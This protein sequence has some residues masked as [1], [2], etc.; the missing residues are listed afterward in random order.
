MGDDHRVTYSRVVSPAMSQLR[1]AL[2]DIC[3]H[4]DVVLVIGWFVPWRRTHKR[5]RELMRILNDAEE[6]Y[7][8]V[9]PD[10]VDVE[11]SWSRGRVR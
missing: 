3:G 1:D 9:T 4:D 7:L 5:S 10:L 6:N 2:F 11:R 8:S